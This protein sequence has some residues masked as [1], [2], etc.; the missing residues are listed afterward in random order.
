MISFRSVL[1]SFVSSLIAM[2]LSP[3]S[4]ECQNGMEQI[5]EQDR[6]N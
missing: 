3:M 2:R 4:C 5:L 6:G 1:I